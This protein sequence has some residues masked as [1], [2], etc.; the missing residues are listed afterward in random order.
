MDKNQRAA[1]RKLKHDIGELVAIARHC[2]ATGHLLPGLILLYSTVDIVASLDRPESKEDVTRTDFVSWV[3][4]YMRPTSTLRCNAINLY[5]A[6]CGLLH[7]YAPGSKLSREGA[8][9]EIYYAW[10]T[11]KVET[12]EK[13]MKAQRWHIPACAIHVDTLLK[14]F[15]VGVQRFRRDIGT[16][17]QKADRVYARAAKFFGAL[18]TDL[19]SR[20]LNSE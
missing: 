17:T 11:G 12:L 14:V 7:T 19:A 9:K 4:K 20:A 6:R 13:L 15:E 1:A 2:F 5:A 3:D 8:A 16:D 18:S 10:G